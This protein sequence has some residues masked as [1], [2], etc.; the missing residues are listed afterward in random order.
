GPTNDTVQD[1]FPNGHTE[2]SSVFTYGATGWHHVTDLENTTLAPRESLVVVT[3][4]SAPSSIPVRV[5][6][7]LGAER[8]PI[9][10]VRL[11]SH[12]WQRVRGHQRDG[13]RHR[14]GTP[15]LC[16]A[17][18]DSMPPSDQ[19]AYYLDR[20]WSTDLP[21]VSPFGGYFVSRVLV[22]PFGPRDEP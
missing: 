17:T 6:L 9:D 20:P 2:L 21:M 8:T 1:L 16:P 4:G 18:A 7:A 5:S 19:F 13:H 14:P 3:D 15:A 12:R 11:E 10:T 22:N